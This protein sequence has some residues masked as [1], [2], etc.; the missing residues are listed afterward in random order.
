M[1]RNLQK[2]ADESPITVSV[3][4]PTFQ[5]E[6]FVESC[7]LSIRRQRYPAGALELIV[8]DANSTDRTQEIAHRL[9]DR[10]VNCDRRGIAFG[11][12]SGAAAATGDVLLF[13]DAD[14]ALEPDFVDRC[15]S[16]FRDPATVCV[17]GIALPR[18]GALFARLVYRAT[19]VLVR[20]FHTVGISLFPGICVAYRNKAFRAVGGF[21]E[22]LGVAEDLDMSR[23]ISRLGKCVI[24][25]QAK[26]AV[27]TRRLQEHALS[28][29]LF[30]IVN[31]LRYLLTGTAARSYPKAEE[32]GRW[33][34]IWKSERSI[35]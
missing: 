11:R 13:V 3:I 16:A 4:V 34:D 19:Y 12:N 2:S 18:D 35:K 22:E 8:A 10:L 29:V 1:F 33:S 20:V 30:H 32:T 6:K 14:A 23:R 25:S 31:D 26:A 27:S 5:E 24:N 15:I 28:V 17:T 7:L 21:R 9:A